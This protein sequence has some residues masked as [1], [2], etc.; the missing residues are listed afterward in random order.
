MQRKTIYSLRR[1]VL[2]K[3]KLEELVLDALEDTVRKLLEHYANPAARVDE[4]D[5]A[6]LVRELKDVFGMET[7]EEA[8]PRARQEAEEFIWRRAKQAYNAKCESA[9]DRAAFINEQFADDPDHT[10]MTPKEVFLEF[11]RERYLIEIDRRW[12]DQLEGMRSLRESV[13]LHGYAQRDPK[14]I[15]KKEGFEQFTALV[16]ETQVEITRV[17]MRTDL[18]ISIQPQR[19]APRP[20]APVAMPAPAPVAQAQPAAPVE[21]PPPPKFVATLGRNDLCWCGSGKKYKLC[22][23]A[24]DQASGRVATADADAKG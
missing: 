4:R 23:L 22:H 15:Y 14:Q 3:E 6:G 19:P 8:I 9:A 5:Y 1:K 16:A 13:G 12:I 17:I 10:P 7:E 24:A 20:A 21:L 2:H 18:S 11:A